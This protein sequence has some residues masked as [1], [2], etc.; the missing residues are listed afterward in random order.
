MWGAVVGEETGDFSVHKQLKCKP[1]GE[2]MCVSFK[3]VDQ[4]ALKRLINLYASL[5]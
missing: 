3:I 2:W 4:H 1:A 5:K